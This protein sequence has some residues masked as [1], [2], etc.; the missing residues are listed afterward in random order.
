LHERLA[1]AASLRKRAADTLQQQA[2]EQQAAGDALTAV[3]RAV[4]SHLSPL[5]L[6]SVCFGFGCFSVSGSVLSWWQFAQ[7]RAQQQQRL[8]ALER[9]LQEE[10]EGTQYHQQLF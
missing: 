1:V 3:M 10:R 2:R 4:R 9:A 6:S 5:C 8:A 7:E